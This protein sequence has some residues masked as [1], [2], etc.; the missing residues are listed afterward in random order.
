MEDG[1]SFFR[2]DSIL[3]IGVQMRFHSIPLEELAKKNK[4]YCAFLKVATN[5]QG[6]FR[7]NLLD[8]AEELVVKPYNIPKILYGMQHSGDDN[9]T[10]DLDNES[11]ILEFFKIPS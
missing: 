9:M 8:L 6:I 4:I 2:V 10:Y 7:C 11:F 3:P 5:R 1:K